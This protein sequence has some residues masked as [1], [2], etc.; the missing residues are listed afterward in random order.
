MRRNLLEATQ[1]VASGIDARFDPSV[2]GYNRNNILGGER[3]YYQHSNSWRE[4]L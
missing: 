4:S 3:W 2:G 1:R